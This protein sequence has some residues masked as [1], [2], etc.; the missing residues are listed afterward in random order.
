MG[1]P[2]SNPVGDPSLRSWR[3]RS[4]LWCTRGLG[5]GVQRG[6]RTQDLTTSTH[7]A[8]SAFGD[9]L[10]CGQTLSLFKTQTQKPRTFPSSK[11]NVGKHGNQTSCMKAANQRE[12]DRHIDRERAHKIGENWRSGAFDSSHTRKKAAIN[13]PSSDSCECCVRQTSAWQDRPCGVVACNVRG[14]AEN[15][16]KTIRST[17]H[18]RK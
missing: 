9:P 2:G 15:L 10:S 14:N 4:L 7:W 5:W 13:Q 6:V 17:E 16:Q 8:I 1:R 11:W 3:H 12:T 18:P